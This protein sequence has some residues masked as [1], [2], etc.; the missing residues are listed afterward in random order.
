MSYCN[1]YDPK[2]KGTK[3][4]FDS[5][6]KTIKDAGFTSNVVAACGEDIDRYIDYGFSIATTSK[7]KVILVERDSAR[8]HRLKAKADKKNLKRLQVVY[9]NIFTYEDI[10]GIRLKRAS[11]V[12][13]LGIGIRF[14]KLVNRAI[15]RLDQ[16]QGSITGE[17]RYL[18]KAQ[19]LDGSRKWVSDTRAFRLLQQYFSLLDAR[20]ESINGWL[21][22]SRWDDKDCYDDTIFRHG[23]ELI[24]YKDN[25]RA[26]KC[27]VYKHDVE[28]NE[29]GRIIQVKLFSSINGGSMLTCLVI[30]R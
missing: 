23:K 2:G 4:V 13:D 24:T 21:P 10:P 18:L 15:G 14:D 27:K 17:G 5:I 6:F 28:F 16:Q 19:I 7:S 3:Y 20:L 9:G 12:E 11:R 22:S 30:Y 25:L 1:K 29:M 8:F 26:C